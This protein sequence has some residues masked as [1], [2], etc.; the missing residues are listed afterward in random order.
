M[1]VESGTTPPSP[2]ST[3]PSDE[4]SDDPAAAP[5]ALELAG[6]TKRFGRVVAVEAVDLRLERGEI[7]ALLG[8]NGAGKTTLMN[9]LFGH[10]RADAGTVRV[11]GERLENHTPDDALAAG[12]GMV[13]QHFT[14]ADDMSVLDNVV[15]GTESLWRPF[16]RRGAARE[17]LARIVADTGLAV[18][19]DAPV[20]TLAVGERQRVEILKALYRDVRV[21]I[22]DEP[23]AV[24]APQEVDE[25]FARLRRL[26]AD[27]LSIVLISHKL[28]EVM[29]ISDRVT[30]LRGGRVAGT[31][32][33]ADVDRETLADMI[34]GRRIE[35]PA[36]APRTPGRPLLALAGA[37]VRGG[38]GRAR[39]LLD[40]V[41]L[42]LREGA[43]VG[44][45]GVAG[46]GQT[47]L[48]DVLSGLRAF[49]AGT[50]S[51]DGET[52]RRPTPRALTRRGLARV[53]EDRHRHGIVGEMTLWEN[54][55]LETLGEGDAWRGG[56]VLDRRAARARAET[57]LERFDVRAGGVEQPAA[58]LSGGNIQKLV[59]ARALSR[60]PRLILANQPTRGLD[61]GAIASVHTLLVAA[62]DA[63]AA[64]LLLTEDLDELLRLADEVVVMHAGR[65][66]APRPA[67][68][69][70]ARA[71]GLAMTGAA[72]EGGAGA[73]AATVAESSAAASHDER[74]AAR[75]S[76]LDGPSP[77]SSTESSPDEKA[78]GS[79][80]AG[81][82]VAKA[83][84]A[85]GSSTASSSVEEVTGSQSGESPA[86]GVGPPGRARGVP[87]A[88]RRS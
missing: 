86:A 37:T 54:L 29:A 70:D 47:T 35:R 5:P 43:I 60:G 21:L 84:S 59:L 30:V 26:V 36:I 74:S 34:V 62:R 9:V 50:L 61:E 73:E 57:L 68:G 22:L 85:R 17:R 45:A 4:P 49:D 64:V 46:N 41:D 58:L 28:H 65:L 44:V 27:G 82:R 69:L 77:G 75:A 81:A 10:Y 72:A 53:P 38:R 18:P 48:A 63:G 83:R 51:I 87:G 19:L 42:V 13:H 39:P 79:P 24:L 7:L 67:A 11:F 31:A 80:S 14:L 55:L 78:P 25:L 1:N 76:S 52:L 40:R 8:E 23:T 32:R 71:L 66:S 6:I 15:L 16:S 88:R 20:R 2:A 56:R 12:V 33:T 3:A